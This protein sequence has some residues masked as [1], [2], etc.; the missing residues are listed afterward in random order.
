MAQKVQVMLVDDIDGGAADETV[1]FALDGTS[2]EIDLTSENA[3]KLR[4]ALA[5]YVGAGAQGPAVRPAPVAPRRSRRPPRR[6]RPRRGAKTARAIR[7]PRP[8]HGRHRQR[9]RPHPEPTSSRTYETA[10]P[11]ERSA[12]RRRPRGVW[13][14]GPPIA[15]RRTLAR[16]GS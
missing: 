12:A 4:D 14:V 3:A 1:T 6:R 5:A 15:S 9:A 16:S 13:R 11:T 8:Q 7:E 10:A 2:Y